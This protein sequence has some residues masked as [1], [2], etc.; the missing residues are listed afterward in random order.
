M[1][2]NEYYMYND[3]WRLFLNFASDKIVVLEFICF[4]VVVFVDPKSYIIECHY[5]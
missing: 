5:C 4:I 3:T 2:L 1:K